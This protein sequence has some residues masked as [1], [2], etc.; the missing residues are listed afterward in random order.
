VIRHAA[1]LHDI[2]KLG[3]SDTILLKHG[4]LSPSERRQMQ[5]H[6]RIGAKILSGSHSSVLLAGE[7]IALTHHERWDGLGYPRRLA[8]EEIPISGRLTAIADVF[9]ALTHTR[10]YKEVWPLDEAIAEIGRLSGTHFDPRLVEVFL[11]LDHSALL[12]AQ[13]QALAPSE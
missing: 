5:T 8:G 3:V 2:G 12:A 11:S 1:P 13:A 10:P 6:T 4:A 7:E 9:D